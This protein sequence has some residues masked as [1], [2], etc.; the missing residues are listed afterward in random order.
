MHGKSSSDLYLPSYTNSKQL[1][2]R[3]RLLSGAASVSCRGL[4]RGNCQE[5]IT[6]AGR[7][8]VGDVVAL[9]SDKASVNGAQKD[10]IHSNYP[11]EH[12]HF[13]IVLII[14]FIVSV[15]Y[16]WHVLYKN[17]FVPG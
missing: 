5:G 3:R 4:Y 11:R 9:R 13:I 14:F 2:G 12:A 8:Y 6:L 15:H 16:A 1:L 17:S 10:W 7:G